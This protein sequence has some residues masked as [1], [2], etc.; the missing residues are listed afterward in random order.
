M[1]EQRFCKPPVGGSIPLASSTFFDATF[2]VFPAYQF[3]L[4]IFNPPLPVGEG[5]KSQRHWMPDRA[6]H[7]RNCKGRFPSP[8]GMTEGDKGLVL[9]PC[10]VLLCLCYIL[11]SCDVCYVLEMFCCDVAMNC[12]VSCYVLQSRR[13][14]APSSNPQSPMPNPPCRS[15]SQGLGFCLL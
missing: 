3:K 14:L 12:Y 9:C 10:Y 8:A 1:A 7:D 4:T 15:G 11:I 13:T 2:Q 6:G 5:K